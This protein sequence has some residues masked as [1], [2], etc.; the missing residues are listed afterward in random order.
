M[1]S[2][3][4]GVSIDYSKVEDRLAVEEAAI[5]QEISNLVSQIESAV[6]TLKR[7]QARKEQMEERLR[8]VLDA[9]DAISRLVKDRDLL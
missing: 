5:R 1:E 7:L 9:R 4:P 2:R 6:A 3:L 8:R